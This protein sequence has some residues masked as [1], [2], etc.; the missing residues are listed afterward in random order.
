MDA[1][2]AKSTIRGYDE[3][4]IDDEYEAFN[5]LAWSPSEDGSFFLSRDRV[6]GDSQRFLFT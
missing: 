1:L 4:S 5:S 2:V 6:M 3:L